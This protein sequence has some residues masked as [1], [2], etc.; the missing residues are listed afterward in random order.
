MHLLSPFLLGGSRNIWQFVCDAGECH[1]V[2]PALPKPTRLQAE[3]AA[4]H[5]RTAKQGCA[6]KSDSQSRISGTGECGHITHG[7]STPTLAKRL[8]GGVTCPCSILP[9]YS[10]G[11]A[12]RR[13]TCT[14]TRFALYRSIRHSLTASAQSPVCFL[15]Q[16]WRDSLE[17]PVK[18]QRGSDSQCARRLTPKL[19]LPRTAHQARSRFS[20]TLRA[21]PPHTLASHSVIP[22]T[23]PDAR[24]YRSAQT[25]FRAEGLPLHC[26]RACRAVSVRGGTAQQVD[27]YSPQHASTPF[28]FGGAATD[29]PTLKSRYATPSTLHSRA[30][31]FHR[32]SPSPRQKP[33]ER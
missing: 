26:F 4:L 17:R 21:E 9:T 11:C 12:V 25:A 7:H 31:R 14:H 5:R 8:V 32:T 22:P 6:S 13:A 27:G 23:S 10:I 15:T 30:L 29:S 33:R 2:R 19:R 20:T 18:G 1:I 28:G 24:R 16:K 3:L